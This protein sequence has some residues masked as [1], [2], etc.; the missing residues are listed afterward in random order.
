MCQVSWG[1]Q[2]ASITKST[3]YLPLFCILFHVS[4]LH[5][6]SKQQT[7]TAGSFTVVKI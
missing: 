5:W 7:V 4:P 2:D 6:M 1:S 3:F